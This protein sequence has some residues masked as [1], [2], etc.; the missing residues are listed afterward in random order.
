MDVDS[1]LPTFWDSLSAPFLT[2]EDGTDF[3]VFRNSAFI[4]LYRENERI[5]K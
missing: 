5:L 2:V 4:Y 3:Y 1:C